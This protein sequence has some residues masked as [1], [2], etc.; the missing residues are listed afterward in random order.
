M[1]GTIG[2]AAQSRRLDTGDDAFGWLRTSDDVAG[3]PASLRARLAQDGYLYLPRRRSQ[4]VI[5]SGR[6]TTFFQRFLDGLH[7]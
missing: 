4:T 7:G 1:L 6:L 5:A 3:E 2:P